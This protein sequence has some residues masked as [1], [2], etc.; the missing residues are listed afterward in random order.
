MKNTWTKLLDSDWF[1]PKQARV[2]LEMFENLL[3]LS[4]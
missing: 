3:K 2:V 4:V 1:C